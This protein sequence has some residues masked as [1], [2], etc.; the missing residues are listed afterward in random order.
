VGEWIKY[1]REDEPEGKK[2]DDNREKNPFD[3]HN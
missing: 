1:Q 2:N 3:L